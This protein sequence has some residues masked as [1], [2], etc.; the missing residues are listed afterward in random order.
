MDL[1]LR[2]SEDDKFGLF[3]KDFLDEFRG[4]N[5][6]S[7]VKLFCPAPIGPVPTITL[8]AQRTRKD[9]GAQVLEV[10]SIC[11]LASIIALL[12]LIAARMD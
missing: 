3:F 5:Q 1:E 8:D 9:G 2:Y 4:S 11:L 10:C 7:L 6:T 12:T